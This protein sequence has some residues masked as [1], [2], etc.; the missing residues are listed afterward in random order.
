MHDDSGAC[1]RLPSIL[2]DLGRGVYCLAN[3][4]QPGV[5]S[6]HQ[7]A[8]LCHPFRSPS[9][10]ARLRI[11]LVMH[12]GLSICIPCFWSGLRS[13]K[14]RPCGSP[15]LASPGLKRNGW[16]R[17]NVTARGWRSLSWVCLLPSRTILMWEAWQRPPAA[18]ILRIG[19]RGRRAL[20][21]NCA[22]P[23]RF[24]W[25]RRILINSHAG[26]LAC[27]RLMVRA[28]ILLTRDTFP[29]DQALDRP[30]RWRR[31]W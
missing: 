5:S 9:I 10:C 15:V 13:M 18:R 7:I 22:R 2:T 30:W 20:L 14:I 4:P 1:L 16:R 27:G 24:W 19:L 31:G 12:S 21:R 23:V 28:G 17:G 8:C 26:W 25:V 29:G 6:L 3:Q 11:F